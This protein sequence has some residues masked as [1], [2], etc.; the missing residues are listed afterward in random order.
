MIDTFPQTVCLSSQEQKVVG[1]GGRYFITDSA[2]AI[3]VEGI[4]L[5]VKEPRARTGYQLVG[6]PQTIQVKEGQT[7]TGH[8]GIP[9]PAPR[10]LDC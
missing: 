8:G 6:T 9:Q 10:E 4:A 5:V 7:V 3:L 2:R 1:D